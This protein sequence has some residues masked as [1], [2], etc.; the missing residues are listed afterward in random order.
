[1]AYHTRVVYLLVDPP[2]DNKYA[3]I[4]AFLTGAY[5]LSETERATSLLGLPGLGD[6]LPSSKQTFEECYY[7]HRNGKK[8]RKCVPPC[9]HHAQFQGNESQGQR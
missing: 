9:K 6:S 3:A 7:H 1:M 8:A 5:E 2:K 4:K